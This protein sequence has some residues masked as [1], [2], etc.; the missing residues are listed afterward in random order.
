MIRVK[1]FCVLAAVTSV[2]LGGAQAVADVPLGVSSGGGGAGVLCET[3]TGGNTLVSLDLFE[4]RH[5]W[6]YE[7]PESDDYEAELRRVFQRVHSVVASEPRDP[8]PEY[9]E[10]VHQEYRRNVE[11]VL[12]SFSYIPAGTRLALIQDRDDILVPPKNCRIVQVISYFDQSAKGR[13]ILVDRE[14]WEMLGPQDRVAFLFHEMVYE[15]FRL[16]GDKTS[17]RARKLTGIMLSS[18]SL[19]AKYGAFVKG[20]RVLECRPEGASE[21][22]TEFYI[23]ESREGEAVIAFEAIDGESMMSR[24][25]SAW[26]DYSLSS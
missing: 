1:G 3:E 25:S 13:R 14:Y 21:A 12:T 9:T 10:S 5:V 11:S 24:P 17:A 8:T 16:F 19:S 18:V 7:I 6:G 4:A 22:G 26:A 20:G 23:G 2:L 15:V